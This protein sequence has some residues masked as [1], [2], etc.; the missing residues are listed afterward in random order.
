MDHQEPNPTPRQSPPQVITSENRSDLSLSNKHSDK[1]DIITELKKQLHLA[2]PL[3]VVSFLQF[4][5]QMISLM[6]VGHL[7][8][9]PLASASLATSF[10]G[11]TGFSLMLGMGGA[12]ETFCGQGYG[13]ELYHMLGVYMQRAMI[14]STLVGI[15]VSIL[16]AFTGKILAILNQDPQISAEAGLYTRWLIPSIFPYA[17]LQYQLRFLQA[18]NITL[19]LMISTGATTLFHVLVCGTLIFKFGLGNKGAALSNGISYWANVFIL[20]LYIKFSPTCQKT[21]K[22]FSKQGMKNLFAFLKLGV[23]SALMVCLEFWSYEFLVIMSAFLPNP[24]LETSMMSISLN[25]SAVIF[26]IPFGFG[27]AVRRVHLHS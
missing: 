15:P 19:P 25:T 22:S 8:Q 23:P 5:L 9:V 11:V 3:V 2:G 24:K 4:S 21:W 14:I 18:Q 1:S 20:A 12:L 6:F 7:G 10:A 13:A 17:I 27:S 26:R 16:W